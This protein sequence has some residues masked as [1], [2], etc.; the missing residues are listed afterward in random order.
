M[1]RRK[2]NKLI[3]G[4]PLLLAPQQNLPAIGGPYGIKIKK[5]LRLQKGDK[6]GLIAPASAASQEKFEKAIFNLESLGLQVSVG[7]YAHEKTGFLAGSDE[8]R[9]SDLHR[10]YEEDSIKAIWAV[11]GGYGTTRILSRLNYKMI[12]KKAKILIGYSDI[13]A[14]SNAIFAKSGVV[15][16]HGPLGSS[17][18]TDYNLEYLQKV[19]F[20]GHVKLSVSIGD[21]NRDNPSDAFRQQVITPGHM[22]GRLAGGNLTLLSSMAGTGLLP[23]FKGKIVFM[24]D[25]GEKPYRIDRMLTQ[26]LNTTNLAKASGILLGV[27]EDCETDDTES[28]WTLEEV[29]RDRLGK[30]GIPVFYGFPIGHIKDQATIPIGIRAQFDT[31]SRELIYLESPVK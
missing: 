21:A 13:T 30:L 26:L 18:F 14:L 9:L 31:T 20:E 19:L 12:R 6:V 28:S 10:M 27:F 5:P 2:F 11:R 7:N 8:K 29:L 1:D 15:G 3:L 23:D 25:I 4:A 22:K 17:D 16:F 24:E